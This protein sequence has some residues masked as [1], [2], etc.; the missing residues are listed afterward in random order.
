MG[1]IKKKS[2]AQEKRTAKE[3]GGKEQIA[4][5]AIWIMKGDVRTGTDRTSGFNEDD[6][7]I[8]NKFTDSSIYKLERK[9]WEKVSKEALHDN[10]RTPLMQV[11]IQELEYV[12]MDKNTFEEL[13][14]GYNLKTYC[15]MTKNKSYNLDKLELSNM[16]LEAKEQGCIPAFI[17]EFLG[18]GG[19]HRPLTLV[20]MDKDDFINR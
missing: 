13:F 1:Y 3:F 8:E 4:S 11:D 14:N 2:K 6:F 10:F 19:S 7:L 9:I 17:I 15:G 18:L 20:L 5:G 16:Y 12:I